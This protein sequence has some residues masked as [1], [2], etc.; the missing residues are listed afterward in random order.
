MSGSAVDEIGPVDFMV[1][2]FAR[3]R[4]TF[5]RAVAAELSRLS[6]EGL[7]RVLDLVVIQKGAD[8]VVEGFEAE[9][10]ELEDVRVLGGGL[11]DLLTVEDV[12]RLGGLLEPGN[13]A[14]VVV[15]ENLWALPLGA[16]AR[17]AG[18]TLLAVGHIPPQDVV[19]SLSAGA[20]DT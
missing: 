12:R 5:D 7:I 9:D 1:V 17:H 18:G 2:Q 8:G 14:G 11:A 15:W 13:V 19:S 4:S 20:G 6:L 16:A 10:L 3:G